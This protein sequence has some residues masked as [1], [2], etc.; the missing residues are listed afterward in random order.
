M[1]G[2]GPLKFVNKEHFFSNNTENLQVLSTKENVRKFSANVR[3][4]V[5]RKGVSHRRPI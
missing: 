3:G 4:K 5:V 2:S 1:T